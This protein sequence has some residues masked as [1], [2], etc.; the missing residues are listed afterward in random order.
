MVYRLTNLIRVAWWRGFMI[1]DVTGKRKWDMDDVLASTGSGNVYNLFVLYYMCVL[2]ML[3]M[4]VL[5]LSLA[6][7]RRVDGCV[8][9]NSLAGQSSGN[10]ARIVLRRF[11]SFL[12]SAKIAN[13]QK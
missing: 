8:P 7:Y 1:V 2:L 9:R 11:L 6:G 10:V 3:I 12:Q 5:R 4:F 13:N